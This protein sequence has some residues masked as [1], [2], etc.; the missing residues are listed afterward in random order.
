MK[1]AHL[2]V[3]AVMFILGV[4]AFRDLTKPI[5][6]DLRF[7]VRGNSAYVFGTT[8]SNSHNLVKNFVRD[9]PQ[10]DTLILQGMPGTIDMNTNRRVVMDIRAAG[11]ATHVP[12]DGRIA[13]GAVDWFIA[14]RPRTI[15]CGAMIGVH[16]WGSP[17]G[18]RA[19]KT[20]FD[21]QRGTQRAF[22]SKMS[23]DPDFYEFTRSAA[24][25][26]DIH[27]LTVE[28]MLRYRLIDK[29]PGCAP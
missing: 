1:L 27:W 5:E 17:T 20:F 8:D 11:L 9:N 19:D 4:M 7:D 23:V 29:D 14:G 26:N 21:A 28:E 18:E 24:G 6:H 3:F 15:E 22:L 13:S 2:I 25:P 12:A 16:S 10:V